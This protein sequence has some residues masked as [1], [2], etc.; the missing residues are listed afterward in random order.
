MLNL[1]ASSPFRAV[2][3]LVVVGMLCAFLLCGCQSSIRVSGKA[4]RPY[5]YPPMRYDGSYWSETLWEKDNH[6]TVSDRRHTVAAVRFRTNYLYSLA[7]VLTLGLWA[8]VDIEW[9][10]NND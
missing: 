6:I 3:C 1:A 9:E 7:T 5:E 2:R 10:E 4:V 8:P